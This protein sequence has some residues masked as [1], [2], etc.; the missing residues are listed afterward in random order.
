MKAAI[1]C[2][3]IA[4][5]FLG[6]GATSFRIFVVFFTRKIVTALGVR[7]LDR[8]LEFSAFKNMHDI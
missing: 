3:V 8:S 7:H 4:M 2:V 6:V 5:S 1:T